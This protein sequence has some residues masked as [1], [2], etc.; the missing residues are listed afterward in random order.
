MPDIKALYSDYVKTLETYIMF[1]IKQK[2]VA[3]TPEL[4][5]KDRKPIMLSIGSPTTRPPE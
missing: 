1:K 4:L 3:L 5:K 2:T